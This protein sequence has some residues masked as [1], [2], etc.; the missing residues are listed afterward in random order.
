MRTQ[1]RVG[2]V[3]PIGLDYGALPVVLGMRGVPR[4]RWAALFDDLRVM[5]Q[6]ALDAMHRAREKN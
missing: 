3:G 5:E 2:A 1:W 6:A 4:R